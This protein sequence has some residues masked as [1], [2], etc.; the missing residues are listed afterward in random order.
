MG[1]GTSPFKIIL[2]FFISGSSDGIADIR[3]WVYG[4]NGFWNNCFLPA[5]ST[6][7]PRYMTPMRSLTCLTTLRSCAIK[8]YVSSYVFFKCWN[9]FKICA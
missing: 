5:C 4:C 1:L 6:I 7:F 2:S 8:I 9:R 3:A